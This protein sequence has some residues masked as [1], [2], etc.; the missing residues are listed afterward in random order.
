MMATGDIRYLPYAKANRVDDRLGS[1]AS[2]WPCRL[3]V[4]SSPNS[5]AKTDIARD[6]IRAKNRPC[7]QVAVELDP[8]HSKLVGDLHTIAQF[9]L[10]MLRVSTLD[11]AALPRLAA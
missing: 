1:F 3:H 9:A 8:S 6:R 10:K 2:V 11:C 7:L 4:R 5:G